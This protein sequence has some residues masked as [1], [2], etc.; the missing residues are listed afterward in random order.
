MRSTVSTSLN[1]E[2]RADLDV[3]FRPVDVFPSHYQGAFTN[4]VRNMF[5]PWSDATQSPGLVIRTAVTD[6]VRNSFIQRYYSNQKRPK[7]RRQ[8][9]REFQ[10]W[11]AGIKT[12]DLCLACLQRI[13]EHAF[14][15]TH[16]FC[17]LCCADLG[18]KSEKDPYCY[19]FDTCPI[20]DQLCTVQIRRCPPTAAPRVL[21][22]DG[23]GVRAV[24]PIQFLLALEKAVD[25]PIPV[26]EHFEFA[27]GTS[28]GR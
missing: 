3:D 9:L 6:T 22:F 23:G 17:E 28:S 13:P 5:F 21:C 26:Q 11:L 19:K 14:P 15:C 25:L 8:I 16:M 12:F 2:T 27:F 20:C 4:A 18:T 1:V 10:P 7:A 24:V